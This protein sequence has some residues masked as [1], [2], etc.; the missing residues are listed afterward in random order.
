MYFYDMNIIIIK[1]F[2]Q[3]AYEAVRRLLTQLSPGLPEFTESSFSTIIESDHTHLFLLYTDDR[4]IGG[5]LTVGTY[6]SP[7]GSKAWIEDVVVDDVY[8]GC[9]YGKAL[10]SYALDFIKGTGADTISLTSKPSRAVANKLYQTMGFS[11]YETN[12]Y[13]ITKPKSQC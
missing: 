12:V 6:S 9:G 2:S 1:E 4:K 11:L 7:S 8:R 13:K 10:V 3:E 5:M